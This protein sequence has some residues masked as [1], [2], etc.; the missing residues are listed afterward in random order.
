MNLKHCYHKSVV[1]TLKTFSCVLFFLGLIV[2]IPSL[3]AIVSW[4]VPLLIGET[5]ESASI[6][7][8]GFIG[9]VVSFT[10][11]WLSRIASDKSF[12]YQYKHKHDP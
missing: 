2:G 11:F 8:S 12:H 4:P 3:T 1:S 7:V 9:A 5:T 6:A 10:L